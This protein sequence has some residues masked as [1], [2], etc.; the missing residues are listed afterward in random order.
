MFSNCIR[1]VSN[2]LRTLEIMRNKIS[3]NTF[4][5]LIA[6]TVAILT[7]GFLRSQ[8]MV[9]PPASDSGLYTFASQ[10][11]FNAIAQDTVIK[12]TAAC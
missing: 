11:I 1:I 3:P 5:L 2:Q 7:T 10:W 8:T 9:Y 6:I 4:H 12:D